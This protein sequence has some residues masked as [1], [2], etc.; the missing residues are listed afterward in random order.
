M[1]HTITIWHRRRD[2]DNFWQK[3]PLPLRRSPP[4]LMHPY[5]WPTSL[6]IPNGIQ[7]Q[8]AVL[9]KYTFRTYR[10]IHR[11]TN[12]LGDSSTPLALT[13]AILIESDALIILAAILPRTLTTN[14][15]YIFPPH[16][17][18][19]C[20]LPC[21]NGKNEPYYSTLPFWQLCAL[22]G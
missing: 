9:P 5:A 14:R 3:L 13:L 7:I 19:S 6:T 21:E 22:K 4:H 11:P 17:I 18:S 8:S 1:L 10:Q 12:G 16:L 2:S 20:A 15:C